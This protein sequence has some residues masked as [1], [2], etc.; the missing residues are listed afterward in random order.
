MK[1]AP[2]TIFLVSTL[3][4]QTAIAAPVKG[5]DN[6]GCWSTYWHKY[7]PAPVHETRDPRGG[8]NDGCWSV[9]W[10]KFCPAPP[11][12]ADAVKRDSD[13]EKDGCWSLFW[14]KYCA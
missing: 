1:I 13:K 5:G 11:K 9:G 4:S 10:H 8:D 6:D 3:V 12:P 7:C 14:H 2:V